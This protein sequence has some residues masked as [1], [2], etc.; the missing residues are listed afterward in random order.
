MHGDGVN[1][2]WCPLDKKAMAMALAIAISSKEEKKRKDKKRKG[3]EEWWC[4][5]A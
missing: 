1:F 2:S 4:G 5:N 3:R